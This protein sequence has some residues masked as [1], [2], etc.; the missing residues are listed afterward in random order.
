MT[1]VY[2][3]ASAVLTFAAAVPYMIQT[4][5]G[6]TKPQVVS[7]G[8]WTAI[9]AIGG[10]AALASHQIPAAV[11]GLACAAEC[12]VIAVLGLREQVYSFSRLDACCL[13]GAV[14]GLVLLLVA[15]AAAAIAAT[16][17]AD[18]IAFVP[19]II[20]SWRMPSEETCSSYVLYAAGG[21]LILLCADFRVFAAVAYPLYLVAADSTLAC[22]ILARRAVL[23]PRRWAPALSGTRQWWRARSIQQY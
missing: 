16:I 14:A 9:T 2:V 6:T 12:A 17:T 15:R 22:M 1:R 18:F 7:W 4:L 23:R 21:A 5:R 19:T 20:H 10:V 11:L 13:A 8:I 3:A